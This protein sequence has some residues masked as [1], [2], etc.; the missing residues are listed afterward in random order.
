M[1]LQFRATGPACGI[2]RWEV[3]TT[4]RSYKN[5]TSHRLRAEV[6]AHRQTTQEALVAMQPVRHRQGGREC[7]KVRT[8]YLDV[9][10][11]GI[12]AA[13]HYAKTIRGNKL[14]EE[15]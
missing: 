11:H 13:V 15:K 1:L 7:G 3:V 8:I 6:W 2:S 12:V 4:S 10:M 14:V 5:M 9:G